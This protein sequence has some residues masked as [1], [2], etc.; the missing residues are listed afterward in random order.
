MRCKAVY[1]QVSGLCSGRKG[2]NANLANRVETPNDVLVQ[3]ESILLK[4][5][6]ERK[7]GGKKVIDKIVVVTLHR[8]ADVLSLQTPSRA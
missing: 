3:A 8:L 4:L 1:P 2:A 5:V 6:L 7:A